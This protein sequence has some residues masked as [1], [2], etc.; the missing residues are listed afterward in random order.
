MKGKG[1]GWG[2]RCAPLCAAT[3]GCHG[4]LEI[5]WFHLCLSISLVTTH[6]SVCYVG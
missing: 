4:L 2:H 6:A 3:C 5:H 1:E